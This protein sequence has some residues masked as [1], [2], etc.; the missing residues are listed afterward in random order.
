MDAE[1]VRDLGEYD[2]VLFRS[3]SGAGSSFVAGTIL[4]AIHATWADVPAVEKN[5]AWPALQKTGRMMGSYGVLFAAIGGT[6]TLVDAV[7]ESTRGKKDFV[8]GV[9]GGFAA[10]SILG[11]RAGRIPVGLG[12]G[13]AMAAVSAFMDAGGQRTRAPTGRE[14]LPYPRENRADT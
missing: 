5:Q 3:L 6:F 10:G 4:G 14:Y 12:A 8:N 1:E 9:I 11:F 13:A 7:S 2:T